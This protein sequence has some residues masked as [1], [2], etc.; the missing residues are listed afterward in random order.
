M[1][2][3]KLTL[4]TLLPPHYIFYFGIYRATQ[5]FLMNAYFIIAVVQ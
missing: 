2:Y 5:F 1:E 3:V 4:S